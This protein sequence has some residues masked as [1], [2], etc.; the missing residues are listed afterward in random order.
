MQSGPSSVACINRGVNLQNIRLTG[1][2]NTKWCAS[3][4]SGYSYFRKVYMSS[5]DKPPISRWQLWIAALLPNLF[6]TPFIDKA[7]HID[8]PVDIY[9]AQNLESHPINF[10]GFEINCGSWPS[11]VFSFNKNPPGLSYFLAIMAF[12]L[13]WSEIALHSA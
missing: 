6:L 10:Y 1:L 8:G 7:F 12:G 4:M 5:T 9:I 3:I 11:W 13:R 2:N